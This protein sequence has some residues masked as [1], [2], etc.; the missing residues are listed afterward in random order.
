[1]PAAWVRALPVRASN[2][3]FVVFADGASGIRTAD[4]GRMCVAQ[5]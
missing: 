1:M 4:L 5:G 2:P 3:P